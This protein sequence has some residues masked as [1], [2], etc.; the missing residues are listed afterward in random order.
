MRYSFLRN[1]VPVLESVR[2]EE[3]SVQQKV[4]MQ[5]DVVNLKFT[6]WEKA[7]LQIGDT[8][9]VF[10]DV[11]RLNS[12]PILDKVEKRKFIYTAT[13]EGTM[14]DLA[15]AGL[16]LPS[17][18]GA[19]LNYAEAFTGTLANVAELIR[20]NLERDFPGVWTIGLIADTPVKT[21]SFDG[22]D[23]CLTGL[24]KAVEAYEVEWYIEGYTLNI[25]K[26]EENSGLNFEYG[27]GKGLYKISRQNMQD[28]P[29]ITRLDVFGSSD[30]LDKTYRDGSKYLLMPQSTGG[31]LEKNRDKYGIYERPV[32]F[33][34][35]PEREGVVT[36]VGSELEFADSTLNFDVNSCL[37]GSNSAKVVFNT[38][39]CAGYTF[40]VNKFNNA[41]KMF[42]ININE[43]EKTIVVPSANGLKPK[44]GDKYFIRDINYPIEYVVDA[45]LRLKA[46]GQDYIDKYST[47]IL[48]YIVTPELAYLNTIKKEIKLFLN[49]GIKDTDYV[50]DSQIRV[51]GYTRDLNGQ[52]NYTA[53]SIAEVSSTQLVTK[54]MAA[55]KNFNNVINYNRLNDPQK[56]RFNWRTTQEQIALAFDPSGNF[57]TEKIR[58]LF[59][60]TAGLLVGV[61]SQ[62]LNFDGVEFY[63][64]VGNDASH[65]LNTAGIVNNLTIN[66]G[67][68][69]SWNVSGQD[70]LNLQNGK[71]YFVFVKADR[72]SA[73]ASIFL[74]LE[75]IV[76][77]SKP[78]FYYFYVGFLSSP[79]DGQRNFQA[80]YGSTT[81][82]GKFIRTGR[83]IGNGGYIDL[84]DFEVNGRIT[85]NAG[86]TGYNNIIDKPD[87]SVFAVQTYVDLVTR[88]L[89]TQ[90]DG[91][92][93]SWF[94]DFAPGATVEPEVQWI[95][96][97]VRNIHLGDLFYFR[98]KGY[99]YRYSMLNGIYVWD[100]ITDTDITAALANAAKAQDTADHKR[101]V[102]ITQPYTPYQEGDLWAQGLNGD[103]LR[104]LVSRASGA[105]VATDFA[106]ASKYT[107]DV[108]ANGALSAANIAANVAAGALQAANNSQTDANAANAL[109]AQIS[110]DDVITASEKTA[111]VREADLINLELAQIIAQATNFGLSFTSYQNA[112][113]VLSTYWTPIFANL[114]VASSISGGYFRSLFIDYY[115]Q[116]TTL[117]RQIS[118]KAKQL[119]DTAQAAAQAAGVT[120]NGALSAANIAANVAA[121]ALQA[122]NN[123]QAAA[124]TANALIADFSND[125][126][127]SPVEKPAVFLQYQN[128]I[129]E[130]NNIATQADSF[131]VNRDDFNSKYNNLT[132]YL[133]SGVIGDLTLSSQI[134]GDYFRAKFNEYYQARTALLK[135]ISDKAKQLADAAQAAAQA[136]AYAAYQAQL[137]ANNAAANAA[138]A[139]TVS[140]A[141][142]TVTTFL[143]TTANG[144]VIATGLLYVGD[145]THGNAGICG[146]TD[147]GSSSIRFFAGATYENRYSAPFRVD[148]DGI[149]TM[150]RADITG[151]ISAQSGNIG[152]WTINADGGL[153]NNQSAENAYIQLRYT[154]GNGNFNNVSLG[155]NYYYP[156]TVGYT[157]PG[158][159]IEKS[160][161]IGGQNVALELIAKNGTTGIPYANNTPPNVALQSLGAIIH[162]GLRAAPA[163]APENY[164]GLVPSPGAGH[165][166]LAVNLSTGELL[167]Y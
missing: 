102:F 152:A 55:T 104:C 119:S 3:G 113:N 4:A 151:R 123:S 132:G 89:Q 8:L 126:I 63:D 103:L 9:N 122:A 50:L 22:N 29:L 94:Y 141:V 130:L 108:T 162:K 80:T 74:S 41:T 100:R 121:G 145:A 6:L 43:D 14:N 154:D 87:L 65:F 138:N 69:R 157:V 160:I 49:V 23:N 105:F 75:S 143:S 5:S 129:G 134:S 52:F 26:R 58:P 70:F 60:E 40:V 120:A 76:F 142:R 110:S 124:N 99:A 148:D 42:S 150:S 147:N 32:Y 17:G 11:Y 59:V 128:I 36:S 72:N 144:N 68:I 56:A 44:I 96:N 85:F 10:G 161:P 155:N 90:I 64:N 112:Y 35:K 48:Q 81:I 101:T 107:D 30:N 111:L 114:N 153:V 116:R 79:I 77:D 97:E 167:Y 39:D 45:E 34:I 38:G 57:Y 61:K 82:N 127:L 1:N 78:D 93:A 158:I 25:H 27:K 53:I 31:S 51:T 146:V 164:G 139:V 165:A 7:N 135:A 86:S 83:L 13:G 109:L 140:N 62:Q 18:N 133:E 46:V 20:Q 24:N 137:T 92:I 67:A 73:A 125:N 88:N 15:R 37:V 98:S 19:F 54:L 95:S 71:P 16:K 117:L 136:A 115:N 159:V 166:R 91:A 84:D 47:P 21:V 118:D 156:N 163:S 106:L 12:L 33:D 2:F 131:G 149:V 28:Q 66:D